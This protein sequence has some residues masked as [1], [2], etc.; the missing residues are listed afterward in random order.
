MFA[1]FTALPNQWVR[2]RP[3]DSATVAF[4]RQV[5]KTSF[6]ITKKIAFMKSG[7]SFPAWRS[8]IKRGS[9]KPSSCAVAW[10]QEQNVPSISS[11]RR[12]VNGPSSTS[13]N[14]EAQI[15]PEPKKWFE[16]QARPKKARNLSQVSKI[17]TLLLVCRWIRIKLY[18]IWLIVA[19]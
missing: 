11:E 7:H 6:W 13:P 1:L 12:L 5:D 8:A 9:I 19:K 10:L 16:R 18:Y 2:I 15:L 3:E 4:P 17:N 14:P